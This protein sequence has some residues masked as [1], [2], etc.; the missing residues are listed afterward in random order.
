MWL[1]W[2]PEVRSLNKVD[3]RDSCHLATECDHSRPFA[4]M[5]EN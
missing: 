5:L 2:K 1:D 4:Y 3:G